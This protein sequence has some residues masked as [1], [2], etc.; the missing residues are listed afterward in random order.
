[1]FC[2][3]LLSIYKGGHVE[4]AFLDLTGAPTIVYNFVH[5]N[6]NARQFWGELILFR[7]KRL[8]MGCG[9]STSQGG[10]VGGHAYSGKSALV[11]FCDMNSCVQYKVSTNCLLYLAFIRHYLTAFEPHV[12][13]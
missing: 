3:L 8:P 12:L 1:M 10:I 4:E 9:T 7:K 6:F 5:H 11:L 13:T 2:C